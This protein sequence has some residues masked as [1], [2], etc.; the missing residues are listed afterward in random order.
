MTAETPLAYRIAMSVEDRTVRVWDLPV[1]LFH[2]LLVAMVAIGV[3]T[4]FVAPEWW[5]GIHTWAGYTIVALL[6]FRIVWGFFGSEYSH[7]ASFT[8]SGRAVIDHL[9]GLVMLRPVHHLGHNPAG[10]VMIVALVFVLTAI[11]VTGLLE[12]GGEEN[13]GPLAGFAGFGVGVAAKSIHRSLVILLLAMVGGHLLG[14]LVESWLGRDNLVR[15]MFTGNKKLPEN[16]PR[17]QPRG[18]RPGAAT[19]TMIVFTALAGG[20]LVM[21]ERMPPTGL[22]ALPVNENYRTECGDCHMAF[23]PSLLPAESWRGLMASLDDHFGEDASLEPDLRDEITQYLTA[24]ASENWGTEAA[25][26]FRRV[27]PEAPWQITATPYWVRKHHE[28]KNSRFANPKV[29]SKSNCVA[30]HSD[31]ASGRF[32]DQNIHMPGA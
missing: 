31:A 16:S 4:G 13:Q 2:W 8:H 10:A 32:D 11:T 12:L 3:F 30:C 7:I 25:N 27:S 28:V 22:V 17:P 19:L 6:A 23:H 14:V 29:R 15:A 21:A 24:H 1:R 20:F 26:Y 9:R 18:A 5:M